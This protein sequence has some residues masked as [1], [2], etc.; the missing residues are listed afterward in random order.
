MTNKC[1]IISVN[2]SIGYSLKGEVPVCRYCEIPVN[3]PCS[4]CLSR[5][6][7]KQCE[8]CHCKNNKNHVYH[9]HCVKEAEDNYGC[10]YFE[11][12]GGSKTYKEFERKGIWKPANNN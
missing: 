3:Q 1:E 6:S 2:L 8:Y 12:H 10:L 4:H 7:T 11:E 5:R 9:Y